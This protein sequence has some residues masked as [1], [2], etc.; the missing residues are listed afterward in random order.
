M[1]SF[2]LRSSFIFLNFRLIKCF[3]NENE[4]QNTINS[5]TMK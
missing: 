1:S 3:K 2:N 5:T 4:S